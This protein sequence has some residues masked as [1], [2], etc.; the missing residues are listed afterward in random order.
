MSR[1]ALI[2][3]YTYYQLIAAIQLKR[4]VLP[5]D[6]VD[7]I[8]TDHSSD[9]ADTAERLKRE[10]LFR[11]VY[12]VRDNDGIDKKKLSQKVMRYVR[13]RMSPSGTVR[14]YAVPDE[15][16]DMLFYSTPSLLVHL[17][18]L[19]TQKKAECYRFEDGYSTYTRPP[20][21]RTPVRKLLIKTVVGNLD[22]RVRGIYLYHPELFLQ[23]TDYPVHKMKLL[24]RA[25]EELKEILNR[26]FDYRSEENYGT[27]CIFLEESFRASG[28]EMDDR[29][30]IES[31]AE[32][33]GSENLM[34]KRHPRV[35][36]SYD[37]PGVRTNRVTGYPWE[38]VLM[39]ENF[40]GKSLMTI[41]SGAS[42]A[43]VLFGF[44]PVETYLLFRCVKNKS[45]MLDDEF[46]E[47]VSRINRE[48]QKLIIPESMDEFKE[49]L[50]TKNF[51]NNGG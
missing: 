20:L 25:D 48:E 45:P 33:V 2:I 11:N 49:I 32:I 3:T 41:T 9:S 29:Q 15:K 42:F 28:T 27:D 30:L 17:M 13:A 14:K 39:N 43:S 1:K 12:F 5:D 22:R 7:I 6:D 18:A 31:I 34:I 50:K 44:E 26:V 37:I 23:Q 38:L 19:Y 10:N 16:Y 46:L 8:I 47:Y 36:E 51:K 4:T 21:E 40:S 24:D 35:K